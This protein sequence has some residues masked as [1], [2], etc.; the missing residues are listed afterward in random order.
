MDTTTTIMSSKDIASHVPMFVGQDFRFWKE[1][2]T[3]YLGAQRLLGYALGQRQR[4]VTANTAQPTQAELVAM[5]DWDEVDLQVK[6]MI[7]MRLSTNLRTLIRT[8]SVAM[9]TNLEQRY[10]VPHFTGIYKDYELAHSIRLTTNENLEIWIQKIWTILERLQANRCVLSNYLQGMLLLKAIP[11]EWDTV[12]QLYCNGMQMANVTFNGV[13]DAIMAGFERTARPAQL[14]HQA[15]KISAVKRKGQ[16]SRFKEQRKLNSAPCPA[17]EAPHGELSV[18]RTRKDG[19]REKA[20]KARA[21]HNIVSS[22]FVPVTVLNRMQETHYTEAGPSTSCVE[23]VVEQPAPTPVTII[24]GPSQAP[25][26]RVS[27]SCT[28]VESERTPAVGT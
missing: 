25:V 24:G 28:P 14:A 4:P 18:K 26:V 10:G 11:K 16:S 2:M 21:A 17:T 1:S 27:P 22:A 13:R 12:V 7:S 15:D 23:E 19:K 3:D 6:S 5:A 8:M 20:R 9:W